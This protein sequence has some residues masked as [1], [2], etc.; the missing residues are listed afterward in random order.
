MCN[1]T[2]CILFQENPSC[3]EH[4]LF[5]QPIGRVAETMLGLLSPNRSSAL[6]LL[7]SHCM[8]FVMVSLH[9]YEL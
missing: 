6:A 7:L 2:I 5:K 4:V 9:H 3:N 8:C 1:Y